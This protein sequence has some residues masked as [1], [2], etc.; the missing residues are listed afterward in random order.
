MT[1]N[2]N[3]FKKR[4]NINQPD[5]Q[6]LNVFSFY[7]NECLCRILRPSITTSRINSKSC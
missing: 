3:A 1:V 6:I 2:E 4:K 7:R 5:K